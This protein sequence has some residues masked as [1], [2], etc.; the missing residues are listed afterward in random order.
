MKNI[1]Q[2]SFYSIE[3]I[4]TFDAL[5]FNFLA[6]QYNFSRNSSF[7]IQSIVLMFFSLEATYIFENTLLYFSSKSNVIL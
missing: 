7:A 1:I 5:C 4:N 2:N 3:N 6:I